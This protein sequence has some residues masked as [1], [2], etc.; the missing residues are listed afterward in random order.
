MIPVESLIMFITASALL[1]VVPGPDNLF[2]LTQ[3]AIHGRAAGIMLSL[4]LCTGLIVHTSAV[5]L[6]VAAIF[7]TSVVAFTVLKVIGAIY[8]VYLAVRAF[9]ASADS[10]ELTRRGALSLSAL[11]RRGILM[12]ITNPKVSIF[13][14]AFLPQFVVPEKGAFTQQVFMLGGVFML[15]ALAVL[16][17]IA[18]LAAGLGY[19]LNR[20]PVAQLYLNRLAGVVFIGLA[21][22]LATSKAVPS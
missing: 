13:F 2:V 18:M 5:A 12:N 15:V 1:A 21:L 14:L 6:G 8:L 19:W 10:V 9:Q 20:S 3:S 22:K 11:Y 16:C 7:Q 17:V 4:G